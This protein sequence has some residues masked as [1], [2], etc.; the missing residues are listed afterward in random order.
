VSYWAEES[1]NEDVDISLHPRHDNMEFELEENK[2]KKKIREELNEKID[3]Y[4]DAT[5][6]AELEEKWGKGEESLVERYEVIDYSKREDDVLMSIQDKII[7]EREKYS[8]NGNEVKAADKKANNMLE[9]GNVRTFIKRHGI[10]T[11]RKDY[12]GEDYCANS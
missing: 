4:L 5:P 11:V 2:E 8:Y 6:S 12:H 1:L 7:E 3:K 9:Y 10:Q